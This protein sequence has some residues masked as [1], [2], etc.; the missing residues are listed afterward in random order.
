M[1]MAV[2][3]INVGEPRR[4]ADR[5][6]EVWQ[7]RPLADPTALFGAADTREDVLEVPHQEIGAMP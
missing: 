5:W 3:A 6:P 7:S 4:A 2:A 1:L